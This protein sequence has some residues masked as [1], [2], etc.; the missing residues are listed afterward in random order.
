MPEDVGDIGGGDLQPAVAEGK[1]G[2]LPGGSDQ[3]PGTG[4]GAQ[5]DGQELVAG[6]AERRIVRGTMPARRHWRPGLMLHLSRPL[7]RIRPPRRSR[8]LRGVRAQFVG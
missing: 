8:P 6:A 4:T 5:A 3:R 7:A 1:A 2:G